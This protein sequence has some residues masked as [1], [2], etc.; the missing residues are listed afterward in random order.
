MPITPEVEV[1]PKASSSTPP[2]PKDVI[3][4]DDLPEEPNT[5]SGNGESGKGA[6]LSHPP[7]E[8]PDVTSAEA[9]AH[10]A[11]K[12][13]LLSHATSTPQ[14]HPKFFPILQKVPLAQRH[15]EISI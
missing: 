15:A 2:N 1:P 10:D 5:E 13:L 3:D 7:P 8:Q 14:T 4:L 6:S 12:R 9:P 11:E